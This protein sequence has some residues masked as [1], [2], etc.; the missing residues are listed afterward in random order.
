M[1]ITKK[2]MVMA[3]LINLVTLPCFGS[4]QPSCNL[5]KSAAMAEE[6]ETMAEMSE[7]SCPSDC[8][9]KTC[10]S[11]CGKVECK[12]QPMTESDMQE[13]MMQSKSV[14][15]NSMMNSM[16]SD[17]MEP[18]DQEMM[19]PMASADM[20]IMAEDMARMLQAMVL[21][22]DIDFYKRMI[23]VDVDFYRDEACT[24]DSLLMRYAHNPEQAEELL[25]KVAE[26]YMNEHGDAVIL[27][28]LKNFK[29]A[30]PELLT[31][32]VKPFI[33]KALM[34]EF[35]NAMHRCIMHKSTKLNEIMAR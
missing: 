3:G 29:V 2:F 27:S 6:Q 26:S 33:Q 14:S 9:E 17:S 34:G 10:S 1:Q 31:N 18:V 7:K 8:T 13:D 32:I 16:I 12:D 23:V 25:Y 15:M 24:I 20:K 22:V 28:L 19:K 35:L 5:T 30:D 4:N 21:L 11:M